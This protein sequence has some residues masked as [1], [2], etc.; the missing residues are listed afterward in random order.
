MK[1]TV[2]VCTLWRRDAR[3]Q[4][5][6]VQTFGWR[7]FPE[8]SASEALHSCDLTPEQQEP[9]AETDRGGR[10]GGCRR[11]TRPRRKTSKYIDKSTT[12]M[13]SHSRR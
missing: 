13:K 9:S 8:C 1:C 11:A 4:H 7:P 5:R 6:H 12:D 3:T 10:G 2:G